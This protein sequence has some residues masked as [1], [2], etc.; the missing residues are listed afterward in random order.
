MGFEEE[1]NNYLRNS[2]ISSEAEERRSC[3][4]RWKSG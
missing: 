1:L 3:I 4:R 2:G